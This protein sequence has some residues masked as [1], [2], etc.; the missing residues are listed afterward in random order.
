MQ[1]LHVDSSILGSNSVSRTLSKEIVESELRRNP[2]LK[3]VYRDLAAQP[4]GH[5]SGLHLAAAQGN[6]EVPASVAEDAVRGV[7]AM[8]EFL[9]SDTIVIGAPMYNF[10][11]PTQLKAWIDRLAVAGKTFKYGPNGPEGLVI[12][13][14]MIIASTRGGA[15]G[16][17]TARGSL[18]HQ[19][20]YLQAV[21]DFLGFKKIEFV[22]AEGL[23]MADNRD[24]SIGSARAAIAGL[25]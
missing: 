20:S 19:E 6:T 10:T 21:F 8:E 3:V 17:Q 25:V 16:P 23:A 5:I 12:G 2:G 14:K 22:R 24:K 15:Y 1:L 9:A 13:R 18:D 7:A 11:I 4:L